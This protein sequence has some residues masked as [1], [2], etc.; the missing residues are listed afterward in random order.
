MTT[1]KFRGVATFTK[2]LITDLQT[3]FWEVAGSCFETTF[4]T[5]LVIISCLGKMCL[6]QVIP[7]FNIF[8]C[9][10]VSWFPLV[11]I[12][13]AWVVHKNS[14]TTCEVQVKLWHKPETKTAHLQSKSCAFCNMLEQPLLWKWCPS[15]LWL[16]SKYL[17]TSSI[18]NDRWPQQSTSTQSNYKAVIGATP[19][20]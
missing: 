11:C 7:P 19:S 12:E 18:A 10:L 17:Q 5:D 8:G 15:F 20:L 4:T 9:L 6:L 2:A 3:G 1:I 14:L 13:D 16:A